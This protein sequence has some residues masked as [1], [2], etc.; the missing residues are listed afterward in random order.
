MATSSVATVPPVLFMRQIIKDPIVAAIVGMQ[1]TNIRAAGLKQYEKLT[2]ALPMSRKKDLTAASTTTAQTFLANG[3]GAAVHETEMPEVVEV[4]NSSHLG[5]M[6]EVRALN[7]ATEDGRVVGA[8]HRGGGSAVWNGPFSRPNIS[9]GDSKTYYS[10]RGGYRNGDSVTK[11]YEEYKARNG[12]N[13]LQSVTDMVSASLEDGL[14]NDIRRRIM[15][16]LVDKYVDSYLKKMAETK[17]SVPTVTSADISFAAKQMPD[18]IP[19]KNN[20]NLPITTVVSQESFS[21]SVAV[22]AKQNEDRAVSSSNILP[23]FKKQSTNPVIIS[24]RIISNNSNSASENGDDDRDD[25]NGDGKNYNSYKNDT[26]VVVTANKAAILF[27]QQQHQQKD[28]A[29][30]K[31]TKDR[32][33]VQRNRSRLSTIHWSSDEEE[34]SENAEEFDSLVEDDEVEDEYEDDDD[35][36]EK[37]GEEGEVTVV[38]SSEGTGNDGKNAIISTKAIENARASIAS[39]LE[40]VAVIE[41][42]NPTETNQPAVVALN[43]SNSE[44]LGNKEVSPKPEKSL[45]ESLL[46]AQRN[47]SKK[48]PR[49][50]HSKIAGDGSPNLKSSTAAATAAA[51][52]ARARKAEAAAQRKKKKRMQLSQHFSAVTGYIR[53]ERPAIVFPLS[54][55]DS[56]QDLLQPFIW[57]EEPIKTYN[58]LNLNPGCDDEDVYSRSE[59]EEVGWDSDASL[60]FSD[61][62]LIAGVAGDE[63]REEDLKFLHAVAVEERLRRKKSRLMKRA[64][65]NEIID[66]EAEMEKHKKSALV[67]ELFVTFGRHRSGSARTEGFYKIPAHEKYKYLNNNNNSSNQYRNSNDPNFIESVIPQALGFSADGIRDGLFSGGGGGGSSN[68][69]SRGVTRLVGSGSGR[70]VSDPQMRSA[71]NSVFTAIYGENATDVIKYNDMRSRK[72]RLRFARSK[73][74]DWGLFA[75]EPIQAD[76]IV[77][78]YIGE[79]I[80]QKV[81]D[82]REKIYEKSGIGSSYLF[83]IDDDNIIDATK[84]GNLAR[85]INHC[86]DPNC[87][88]KIITVD[89]QKKIVIYANKPVSEG[90][91]IT[92]DYKFPIEEDKIPC[93]CGAQASFLFTLRILY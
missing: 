67:D 68:A 62:D 89:G 59:E 39:S 81:A 26:E 44:A 14:L 22:V 5:G 18:S 28:P 55:A 85:F 41:V 77:I 51:A 37:E 83:R 52:E 79:M 3:A 11:K 21:K 63:R 20:G 32:W 42:E 49:Q 7:Y 80:R 87:N 6:I 86:C 29:A 93:L 15:I 92:Y 13:M 1:S 8:Q 91:E 60:D 47:Y 64:Q 72:N 35:D 2:S 38:N 50:N 74:H 73:I 40:L 71:S 30:K 4:S 45:Y 27:Q 24:K 84:S 88:A 19:F 12:N 54:P 70:P 76:D 48:R 36:E 23:S 82:H 56:A 43:D 58:Y 31:S 25:E 66:V 78:E 16:P 69:R 53:P 10:D 46:E 57:P 34:K 75:L 17:N 65:R 9:V 61:L 33:L 90:E